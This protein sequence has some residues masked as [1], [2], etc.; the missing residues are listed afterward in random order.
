MRKLK[1]YLETFVW[2]FF[3]AN[4]APE[5]RDI[6]KEFFDSVQ[7]GFYEIYVS[8]VVFREVNN[9]PEDRK[10]KIAKLIEQCAPIRL[11]TV[12]QAETLASIYLYKKIVPPAKKDD[13]LHVAI[14]TAFEMDAV[15]TWNYRHLANLRKAELFH[16]A[17]LEAGYFKKIE[18]VTPMEVAKYESR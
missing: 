7:K 15:I 12:E 3:F 4:D 2:N 18:I 8:D 9:A 16:S 14:A 5:K 11:D 17:N 13:A 1:L 6:T 10:G